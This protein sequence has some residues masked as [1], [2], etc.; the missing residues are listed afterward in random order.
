MISPRQWARW[1]CFLHPDSDLR[2]QTKRH[3]H[4][5]AG[6]LLPI[7]PDTWGTRVRIPLNY[8][9]NF[10]GWRQLVRCPLPLLA[11]WFFILKNNSGSGQ[12]RRGLLASNCGGARRAF[13]G[14]P[15]TF[16]TSFIHASTRCSGF[17]WSEKTSG[18]FF[19]L[20]LRLEFSKNSAPLAAIVSCYRK[21]PG[22]P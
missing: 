16:S 18:G 12:D 4:H 3:R 22:F 13:A 9:A 19:P 6:I 17:G 7:G 10:A 2:M 15:P 21:E 1:R 11:R 14:A 5:F 8:S 20:V